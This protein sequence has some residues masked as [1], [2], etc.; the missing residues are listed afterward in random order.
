[1][2]F[3]NDRILPH[4]I[5]LSMRNREFLPYRER[6]LSSAQGRVLEIG[7]GS[8][9]N[10]PFYGSRVDEILGL[11]PAARLIAMAQGPAGRSRAPMTL[12]APDPCYGCFLELLTATIDIRGIGKSQNNLWPF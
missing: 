1:M 3:Y 4:L 5:N 7:I 8:G 12:I 6:V 11:E 2:S 9:L 10:L